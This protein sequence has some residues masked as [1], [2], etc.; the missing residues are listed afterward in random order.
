VDNTLVARGASVREAKRLLK[1]ISTFEE[2]LEQEVS[3]EE[4][5]VFF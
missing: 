3:R 5:K 2:A 4:S 1:I